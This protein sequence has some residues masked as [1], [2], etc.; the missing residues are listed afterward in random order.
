MKRIASSLSDYLGPYAPSLISLQKSDSTNRQMGLDGGK[1]TLTENSIDKR[2]RYLQRQ[3]AIEK[4]RPERTAEQA[5][6]VRVE[7]RAELPR[8]VP[9]PPPPKT[10]YFIECGDFIKIGF[11][12]YGIEGR[13]RKLEGQNPYPLKLLGTIPGDKKLE[14]Q[15]HTRFEKWHHHG[16]WFKRVPEI[17]EFVAAAWPPCRR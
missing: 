11:T 12:G 9:N 5:V 8:F 14:A 3:L 6:E 4:G 17:L 16:E 15:L 1:V 10:I 13:L 7:P 2:L